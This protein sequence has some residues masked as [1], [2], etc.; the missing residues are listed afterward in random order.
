VKSLFLQYEAVINPR[1]K[2]AET[3]QMIR[4]LPSE[5]RVFALVIEGYLYKDVADILHIK[6]QSVKNL[7]QSFTNK[8]GVKNN[9]Q[10][11]VLALKMNLIKIKVKSP[12]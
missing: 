2:W 4:V 11:L 12:K 6:P 7:M 10:A 9:T 8:I 3:A 5:L 1:N